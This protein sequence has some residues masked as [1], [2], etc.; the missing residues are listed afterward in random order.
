MSAPLKLNDID[1]PALALHLE[2]GDPDKLKI[3]SVRELYDLVIDNSGLADHAGVEGWLRQGFLKTI[4]A[5]PAEVPPVEPP[6]FDILAV[7]P[8]GTIEADFTPEAGP[9]PTGDVFSKAEAE[10]RAI[11]ER[12]C[13]EKSECRVR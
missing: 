1:L 12:Q 6:V 7:P 10:L 3:L 8:D 9:A 13:H 5:V 4:T 11:R 2:L